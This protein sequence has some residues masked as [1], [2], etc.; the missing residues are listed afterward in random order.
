MLTV[1]YLTHG[2]Q[3]QSVHAFKYK[4]MQPLYEAIMRD[5]ITGLHMSLFMKCK[6]IHSGHAQCEFDSE[7]ACFETFERNGIPLVSELSRTRNIAA[8]QANIPHPQEP[9]RKSK[10]G[11]SIRAFGARGGLGVAGFAR[12]AM[13]AD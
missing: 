6:L 12:P 13:L 8:A 9:I 5:G 1:R 11:K 7:T 2:K 3:S 4:M 10:E